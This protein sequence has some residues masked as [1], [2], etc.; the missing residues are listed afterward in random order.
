[1]N[2]L[3]DITQMG[4]SCSCQRGR[5]KAEHNEGEPVAYGGIFMHRI[6]RSSSYGQQKNHADSSL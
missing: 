6:E 4:H 1:M 5:W 2:A 3:Y